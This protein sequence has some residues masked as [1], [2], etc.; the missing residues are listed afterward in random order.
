MNSRHTSRNSH[1][2]IPILRIST[3]ISSILCVVV[4]AW[5]FKAH[6]KVYTDGAGAYFTLFP[7]IFVH[8]LLL[9][10][11]YPIP[12]RLLIDDQTDRIRSLLVPPNPRNPRLLQRLHPPRNLHNIRPDRLRH[13]SGM[14]RCKAAFCD[15]LW[16][17]VFV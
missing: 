17:A 6:N 3:I 5:V 16:I 11:L 1:P 12:F 8:L 9:R 4:F 13:N 10:I 7:L 15:E 2:A 14:L